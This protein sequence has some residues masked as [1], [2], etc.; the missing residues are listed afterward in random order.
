MANR[1]LGTSMDEMSLAA[2]PTR[3]KQCTEAPWYNE[4]IIPFL[5]VINITEG[6]MNNSKQR[7]SSTNDLNTTILQ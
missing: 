3:V 7:N 5:S 2:Q 4:H 6:N 1:P